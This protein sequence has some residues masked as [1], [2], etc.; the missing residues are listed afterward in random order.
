MG[1]ARFVSVVSF[2]LLYIIEANG[3][4]LM[5]SGLWSCIRNKICQCGQ[6][7]R[8]RRCTDLVEDVTDRLVIERTSSCTGV[9]DRNNFWKDGSWICENPSSFAFRCGQQVTE[10][11]LNP[12]I[13][14]VLVQDVA[15]ELTLAERRREINTLRFVP[16][17][18]NFIAS[19]Q[20]NQP[21][22]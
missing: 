15:D 7:N 10:S 9:A 22:C 3:Q 6:G 2:L 13:V 5:N 14:P 4:I 21:Q 12:D 11:F 18:L 19:C 16:C 17:F 20:S 8:L 1:K